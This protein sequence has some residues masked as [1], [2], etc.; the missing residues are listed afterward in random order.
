MNSKEKG[1]SYERDMSRKI[2]LYLSGGKRKDLFWRTAL[3]GAFATIHKNSSIH[4]AGQSG[5][6]AGQEGAY[7]WLTENVIYFEMKHWRYFNFVSLL[8]G[9]G[10]FEKSLMKAH[11]EAADENKVLV[12]VFKQNLWRR[13]LV[14]LDDFWVGRGKVPRSCVMD[15]GGVLFRLEF[16]DEFAS[17][18]Y[19]QMQE[20]V[21]E[22]LYHGKYKVEGNVL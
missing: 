5:D 19:K 10:D 11:K 16:F 12:F 20:G 8:Y 22:F 18:L 3:S 21:I 1:S 6:I 17:E 14:L 7:R 2:S 9:G 13:D 15:L 4:V